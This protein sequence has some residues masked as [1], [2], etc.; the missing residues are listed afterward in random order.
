MKK[1]RALNWPASAAALFLFA[2]NA[3]ICRELF[4]A[5]FINNLSS[6]EGAFVAFSRFYLEHVRDLNWFPW[7]NGGIPIENAYQPLLPA[8][9]ALA[10]FVSGWHIERSFHFLLAMVYCLGPVTLF[11]FAWDWSKSVRTGLFAGLAYSL[12]S[13]GEWAIP[14]LRVLDNGHWV[15][16]RFYNLVH[17]AEDPHNLALT[18]LPLALFFLRRGAWAPAVVSCAAVLLSNAF[19][20][21]DL[22]IGGLCI[23]LATG[24]GFQRLAGV[25]LLA[26]AWAMPWL[27]PTLIQ[28]IGKD[29]FGGRGLFQAGP[30]AWLGMAATI[31]TFALIWWLT[32]RLGPSLDRFA[33]LFVFPM[34]LIPVGFFQGG[35]TLVPQSNR[36]QLELEMAV[37]LVLG[38]IA[39]RIP[40]RV[41][42]VVVLLGGAWQ[43]K[44]FRHAARGML[45]PVEITQSIQ[46]KT[47]AAVQKLLP[48]GRVMVSGDTEFICNIFWDTPQLSSGHQP[49][50]PNFIQQVAV[51]QTY[52]GG[53]SAKHAADVSLLWL[54]AF[55]TQAITVPGEKSREFYHP[56][57]FPHRYDGVLPVLW[58]DEDDSIFAIPQ[59]SRSLARV[60][61]A[62]VLVA[63]TPIHGLDVEPLRPFVAAL[64]DSSMP[65]AEL[66]WNSTTQARIRTTGAPGQAVSVAINWAPGWRSDVA[67]R[68][69]EVRKDGIGLIALE[70]A[71][72]GPCEIHLEYGPSP[73]AW[74]CRIFSALVTLLLAASGISAAVRKG[75]PRP[76]SRR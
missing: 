9:G 1:W 8:L 50:A 22:A 43:A 41:V 16:L 17:Y 69:V 11:L 46:Y 47:C 54:K 66:V 12:L 2:L 4:T 72:N 15:P 26:Y 28:L 20:A 62:N 42:L 35:L 19:G 48:G 71:C 67:G 44:V 29:Q 18:L 30:K 64:D 23:V 3:Y 58:H 53:E 75:L 14:I 45:Q 70:P 36:Y 57:V 27:P 6:N 49:S 61:P 32:R 65:L 5:S 33:L 56:L 38:C 74:V 24:R 51:Y 73:E 68:P 37:C 25:G 34:I 31:G 7:F 76:P 63:R 39:A 59:P 60:V 21:V 13:P 55:G 52:V 40:W 10:A